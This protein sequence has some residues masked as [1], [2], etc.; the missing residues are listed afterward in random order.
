M[1]TLAFRSVVPHRALSSAIR[2]VHRRVP[3]DRV[4]CR[5]HW[6][7]LAHPWRTAQTWVDIDG[8]PTEGQDYRAGRA[9]RAV[10]SWGLRRLLG[11]CTRVYATKARDIELLGHPN[12]LIL[13]C[14]ST[15][16]SRQPASAPNGRRL[17]FVGSRHF[18][19]NAEAIAFLLN[20]ILPRVRAHIPDVQL[21]IVGKGNSAITPAPNLLA[22]DFVDDLSAEYAAATLCLAPVVSGGGSSVKMAEAAAAGRAQIATTFAARGFADILRDGHELVVG[23]N[24]ESFARHCVDLLTDPARR[25]V[26]ES[27]AAARAATHL[28]QDAV[29]RM[30]AEHL[31]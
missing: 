10:E 16:I 31:A 14:I 26:I 21:R 11:R 12:G 7:L 4:F 3:I 27:A 18:G 8:I 20:E 5:Y 15:S 22:T 1:E 9:K 23:E 24:A 6:G 2:D 19:P 25:A 30:L 28:S 17:L 13:P 29:D